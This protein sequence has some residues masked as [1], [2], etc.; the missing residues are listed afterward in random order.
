MGTTLPCLQL[1]SWL[2]NT[3]TNMVTSSI[4]TW[5]GTRPALLIVTADEVQG[6]LSYSYQHFVISYTCPRHCWVRAGRRVD[7]PHSCFHQ[8][9]GQ[10]EL[11]H[12]HNFV[13]GSYTPELTELALLCFSSEVQGLF[14]HLVGV[15]DGF[16]TLMTGPGIPPVTD[17]VAIREMKNGES[18]PM[19]TTSGFAH[20]HLN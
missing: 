4:L 5:R 13:V 20:P 16:P 15:G 18:F 12:A 10:C 17:H 3:C 6:E 1:W 7:L 14:S 8:T 2:T 9:D 11:P 19:L